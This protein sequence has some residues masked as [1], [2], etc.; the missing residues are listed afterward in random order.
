[1]ETNKNTLDQIHLRSEQ[2]N[3]VLEN[4]PHWLIRWG[5][6]VI[7]L[8]IVLFFTLACIIKYP[9][10][11]QGAIVIS[12]KN[13][14]E[15][16]EAAVNSKIEKI[17]IADQQVVKRGEPIL[18]LQSN[19]NYADVLKL[20]AILDSTHPSTLASFPIASTSMLRLGEVQ[21]DYTAFAKAVQDELL[22]AKLRPYDTEG[23]TAGKNIND[24]EN[25]IANMKQQYAIEEAKMELTEKNYQRSE[26]LQQQG[27]ISNLELE[28]EKIRLL[29]Q[30]KNFKNT[31]L[32]L[33]QLEES[34]L[35]FKKIQAGVEINKSKDQSN[36]TTGSILMLEKLRKSIVQWERN[37][38]I[39]ASIDGKVSYL[40]FLGANQFVKAGTTLLSILPTD[41]AV[42]IGQMHIAAQNQGKIQKDQRVLIKLDNYKYQ[43]FGIVTGLI[44]SISLTPDKDA[45]YYVEVA[46][47][48]GLETSYHKKLNFN[49]ELTG[50]ADI[51]T[52]ELTL[53]QRILDQL[54]SILKYQNNG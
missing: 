14:P 20:K 32:S 19:A 25:R 49:Q 53:A 30:R 40:Q 1:M 17:F 52:E 54:R 35:N 47:P 39:R 11:I 7:C 15:K 26:Q 42:I 22:F 46:L 51:V 43:E 6:T 29:E 28:N 8:L 41:R 36:Y 13:P 10:F 24:Y 21:E 18:V 3:D 9:E 27:V 45:K 38:L 34:I 2:V 50:N 4:P 16:I 37:Y 44:E 31:Q 33:A 12:S 23:L 48:N 5:S